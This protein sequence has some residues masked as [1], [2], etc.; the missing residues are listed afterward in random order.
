MSIWMT[1]FGINLKI[2][3]EMN[4]MNMKKTCPC[5]FK[6]IPLDG[7]GNIEDHM[8]ENKEIYRNKCF[9]GGFVPLEESKE[10]LFQLIGYLNFI[11]SNEENA[12]LNLKTLR[13]IN[14][15]SLNEKGEITLPIKEYQYTDKE[16]LMIIE[17]IKKETMR[18][19]DSIQ[20]ELT[21]LREKEKTLI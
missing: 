18:K 17:I 1:K 14:Y 2:I 21:A 9:G 3:K 12:L 6:K 15:F 4:I 16:F 7:N 5:C 13:K 19:I 10:G 8:I 20:N 11:K